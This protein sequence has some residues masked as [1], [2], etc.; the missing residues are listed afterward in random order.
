MTFNPG[1]TALTFDPRNGSIVPVTINAVT[2]TVTDGQGYQVSLSPGGLF[3]D[4]AEL[5][6][7][8]AAQLDAI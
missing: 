3:K 8:I 4:K 1:D 6:V 7:F 5:L 2:Y